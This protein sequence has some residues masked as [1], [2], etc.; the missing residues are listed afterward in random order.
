LPSRTFGRCF[1]LAAVAFSAEL[2]RNA[3]LSV[4]CCTALESVDLV[5]T[6]VEDIDSAAFFRWKWTC[7]RSLPQSLRKLSPSACEGTVGCL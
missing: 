7:V 4:M 1:R 3:P 2:V 5:A 6:A